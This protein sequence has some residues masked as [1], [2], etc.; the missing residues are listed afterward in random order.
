MNEATGAWFGG[1][2][3]L[4]ATNSLATVSGETAYGNTAASS[5]DPVKVLL[6]GFDVIAESWSPPTRQN[7]AYWAPPTTLGTVPTST[8]ST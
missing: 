7:P 8:P 4:P 1:V 2:P 3:V 5:I 6:V